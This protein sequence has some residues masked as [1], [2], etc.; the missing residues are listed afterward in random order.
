M[1]EGVVETLG[2]AIDSGSD[3]NFQDEDGWNL[4]HFY[5]AFDRVQHRRIFAR[6]K[7][8]HENEKP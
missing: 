8:E 4:L 5:A 6:A 2:A 3:V 7:K 1:T